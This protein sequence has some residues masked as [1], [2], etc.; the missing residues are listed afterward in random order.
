MSEKSLEDWLEEREPG[1]P[2]PF[3]PH[4]VGDP[5]GQAGLEE[6]TDLGVGALRRALLR[7]GRDRAAAFDLLAADAFLTYACEGATMEGNV[8]GALEA[9]LNQVGERF[10]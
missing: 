5:P 6:L 7:P 4:L 8:P 1:I 9:I 2:A 3:L 10:S